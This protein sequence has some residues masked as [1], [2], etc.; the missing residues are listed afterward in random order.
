MDLMQV[1]ASN[2]NGRVI[3]VDDYYATPNFSAVDAD[4]LTRFF[5][6]L[7]DHPGYRRKLAKVLERSPRST[8]GDL[9][10][11]VEGAIPKLWGVYQN[12]PKMKRCL[13][14]LF[15]ALNLIRDGDR[16][17]LDTICSYFSKKH[18]ITPETFGSLE[19]AKDALKKCSI[20]FVDFRF[21]AGLSVDKA[22][23]SHEAYSSSYRERYEYNGA[24]FPKIVYLISSSLPRQENLEAFRA[25]T[26]LRAA[27]FSP[28]RKDSISIDALGQEFARWQSQYPAAQK[29]DTYLTQT[30]E[31]VK[32]AAD[33]L[34]EQLERLE[35]HELAML[36]AF[37]LAIEQ[38]S[39]QDYLTW[40]L[41]ESL[42][43]K[44]RGMPILQP[45]LLPTDS[46]LP[47]DGKL[48]IGAVLF[49][50]FSQIAISPVDATSAHPAFGDV[51]AVREQKIKSDP[52]PNPA[53][54]RDVALVISPAC[55][56]QRCSV[57]DMVL[58]VRG[59]ETETKPNMQDLLK[60][61]VLFGKGSHVIQYQQE[62]EKRYGYMH[63][64]HKQII[65]LSV[66][67]LLNPRKHVK[68]ARLS[69][70]FAQ[71]QK[72]MALS[73]ASRIGLPVYPSFMVPTKTAVRMKFG[74]VTYQRD[75]SAQQNFECAIVIK[76][77]RD[78]AHDEQGAYFLAFTEQFANWMRTEFLPSAKERFG[79]G[80]VPPKFSNVENFMGSWADLHIELK[81]GKTHSD[82]G[83][84]LKFSLVDELDGADAG[85]NMVEVVV[86]T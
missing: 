51:Y 85:N 74:D 13:D 19:E 45:A 6:H 39:L 42:A 10:L 33:A 73:N 49:E 65:T 44:L 47:L 43:S 12:D 7:D 67:D 72:E 70:L 29:L 24:K 48:K 37:K 22:I 20:A 52:A 40:L 59:K 50:L 4:V 3:V 82:V 86:A 58:C 31:A 38:E 1:L 28:M 17:A 71:E 32:L 25:A 61:G 62:N 30:S 54:V 81:G 57:D 34:R 64:D 60:H 77:R 63:W 55:D 69:E 75:L 66:K 15:E 14:P 36:N 46:D 56:L 2:S 21:K 35:L 84:A 23:S 78:P 5:R 9:M 27:F 83:G 41:S 16:A 80:T 18:K 53:G 26:G 79:G 11:V 8:A 76:G 68:V